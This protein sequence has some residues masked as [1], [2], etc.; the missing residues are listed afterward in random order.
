MPFVGLGR[1][2]AEKRAGMCR[3]YAAQ[4][5]DMPGKRKKGRNTGEK[6]LPEPATVRYMC[7][8]FTPAYLHAGGKPVQ[9]HKEG[10]LLQALPQQHRSARP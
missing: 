5:R 4:P 9:T 7:L 8:H 6:K 10:A 1:I 2:F 3:A